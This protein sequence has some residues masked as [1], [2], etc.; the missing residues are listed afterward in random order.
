MQAER[1]YYSVHIPDL[2][3]TQSQNWASLNP[4]FISLLIPNHDHV[5]FYTWQAKSKSGLSGKSNPNL[6]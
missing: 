4:S 6:I 3:A 1:N 2:T 5:T